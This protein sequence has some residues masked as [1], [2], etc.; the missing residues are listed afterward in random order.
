MSSSSD[1]A[2]NL[3]LDAIKSRFISRRGYWRPWTEALLRENPRFLE[4][5][6]S[7]ASHPAE[8]GPLTPRMIELIYV[9]LDASSTHLFSAGLKLHIELAIK[10]GATHGELHDV[11]HR[12]ALQGMDRMCQAVHVLA[13][14]ARS[15]GGLSLDSGTSAV[16]ARAAERPLDDAATQRFHCRAGAEVIR[17]LDQLD[18]GFA[19]LMRD[20]IEEG[21]PEQGLSDP[22]RALIDVALH[23]CFTG[24]DPLA[25]SRSI[26]HAFDLGRDEAELLQAIQLG[27]HLAV[28]GTALGAGLLAE[29]DASGLAVAMSTTRRSPESSSF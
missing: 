15:R 24:Y 5:Y 8:H 26:S 1:R 7:Y 27:A 18:P 22:D 6:A 11:F 13:D 17:F 19:T 28:H 3:D 16:G 25:L 2:K 23:A 29:I 4:R 9:A 21:R 14:A 20:L 12:V 10:A